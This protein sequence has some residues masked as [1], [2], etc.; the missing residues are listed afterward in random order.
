MDLIL[1]CILGCKTAMWEPSS[2]Q[3]Q[4]NRNH[5]I[6]IPNSLA[7]ESSKVFAAHS[8]SS[9]ISVGRPGAWPAEPRQHLLHELP[10]A[11]PVF[12]PLVHQVAGG[13]HS[14]V[15]GRAEPT[16]R[17]AV[18]VA[19]SVASPKRYQTHSRRG[20]PGRKHLASTL[21][22]LK[23]RKSRRCWVPLFLV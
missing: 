5:V 22:F 15:Q 11:R 6:S 8:V 23:E 12:V 17:A 18:L 10:A 13:V 14:T 2:F 16:Q 1:F 20:K 7:S 9:S 21:I 4:M 3:H 19:H